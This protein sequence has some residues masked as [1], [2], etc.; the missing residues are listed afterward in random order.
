MVNVLSVFG[1][2]SLRNRFVNPAEACS[3]TSVPKID[4]LQGVCE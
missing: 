2:L 3:G 1:N 4:L